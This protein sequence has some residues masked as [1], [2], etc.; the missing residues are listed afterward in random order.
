[1]TAMQVLP[2]LEFLLAA[3]ML[4]VLA[5]VAGFHYIEHWSWLD[6]F[7]MVLTMI[8]SIGYGEIHPLSHIGRIFNSFITVAGVGL[9]MVLVGRS[10]AGFARIRAAIGIR[11][12]THGARDQPIV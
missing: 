2:K 12:E 3:L 9:A 6:G 4:P 10:L 8:M 5:G 1:M 11:Q 7:Y